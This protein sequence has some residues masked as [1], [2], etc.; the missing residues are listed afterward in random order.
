MKRFLFVFLACWPLAA[1][2][3]A[4]MPDVSQMSGMPLPARELANAAVSVRVVRGDLNN[5]VANQAVE[6]HGAGDVR[7]ATTDE[8]GRALFTGMTPGSRVHAVTDIDGQ[9]VESQEFAVPA[10]GGVRLV[11]VARVAGAA[12]AGSGST[13]PAG[14][15]PGAAAAPV[16]LGGQS[17][18]VLEVG[19]TLDVY[20]PLEIINGQQAP[21]QPP[22]PLVFELPTDSRGASVLE[23]SSPLAKVEGRRVVVSG[24]FPAGTTQV[25]FAYQIP[26]GSSRVVVSQPLPLALPQTSLLVRKLQG[27]TFSSAQVATQRETVI[28]DNAYYVASGP[29]LAAG[30]TLDVQLDGLPHHPAWPRYLALALVALIV[31]AGVW[32]GF[33][34]GVSRTERERHGLEA[35]REQLFGELVKLEEQHASGRGSG[36]RYEGRR[37]DLVAQLEQVYAALDELGAV[38]PAMAAG[39]RREEV[40][41]D[42]PL[43]TRRA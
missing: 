39:T 22:Q 16:A 15:M 13:P 9:R 32:Y 36:A 7:T 26:Y 37:R 28:D 5:N 4:Q 35:R 8:N 14:T 24:P 10:S 41:V 3:V 2:A 23:G 11:L 19:E 34:E 6:L 12:T 21:V 1:P 30:T 33:A 25:Q 31:A 29:A 42:A 20:A 38:A 40:P 43:Q 27:M 17:R 18:F